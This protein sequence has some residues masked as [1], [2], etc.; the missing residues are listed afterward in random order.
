MIAEIIRTIRVLFFRYIWRQGYPVIIMMVDVS[1]IDEPDLK[2][3]FKMKKKLAP[4]MM[5]I[6]V[7]NLDKPIE[8]INLGYKVYLK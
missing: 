3:F 5:T 6:C 4:G 1:K 8:I 2:H 7:R